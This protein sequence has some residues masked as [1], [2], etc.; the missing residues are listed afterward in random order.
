MYAATVALPSASSA[1]P[2]KDGSQMLVTVCANSTGSA[3]S[4]HVLRWHM[5]SKTAVAAGGYF[6][7]VPVDCPM[8]PSQTSEG[9]DTAASCAELVDENR[10]L[11]AALAHTEERLAAATAQRE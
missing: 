3:G 11:K 10:R 9:I 1:P 2:S 8:Q 7:P 6:R 4:L 5:P